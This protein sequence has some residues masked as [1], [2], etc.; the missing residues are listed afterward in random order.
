M[1][2]VGTQAPLASGQAEID[3]VHICYVRVRPTRAC[4]VGTLAVF[5]VY[6]DG[7]STFPSRPERRHIHEPARKPLQ[8]RGQHMSTGTVSKSKEA[9]P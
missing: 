9:M 2:T 6:N 8:D 3:S 4:A 5:P 1:N 7:I